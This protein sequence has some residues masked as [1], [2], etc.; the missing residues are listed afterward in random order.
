MVAPLRSPQQATPVLHHRV[1]VFKLDPGQLDA[2]RHAFAAIQALRDNR[3]LW[4]WAGLH[5][6]PGYDCEHTIR[7]VDSLFLPWHRAYLYHL[8]LALQTQVPEAALPWWDWP[9]SRA[10]GIPPAFADAAGGQPANPLAGAEMPPLPNAPDGWPGRTARDPGNPGELP[11][12]AAVDQILELSDFNDFSLQLEQQLHNQIHGWTGGTMGVIATAAYDP[13]FWAHHTMV[14]RLW[15]LWQVKH[16]SP[17]PAPQ[18]WGTQLRAVSMTIGDVL[19][20]QRLGYDYAG[21]VASV[22][23]GA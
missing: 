10:V 4:Y 2:L 1:S 20:I 16:A 3:G 17:G 11:D 12:Q 5:G 19:S 9:S 22:T 18:T 14:D 23:V 7:Q 13:I 15:A 6:A 21:S 8:E